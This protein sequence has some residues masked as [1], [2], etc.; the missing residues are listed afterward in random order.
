M[1]KWIRWNQF[2]NHFRSTLPREEV[3]EIA[4]RNF[5]LGTIEFYLTLQA[6]IKMEFIDE[7]YFAYCESHDLKR[8]INF[9]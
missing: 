5:R 2:C 7:P 6:Q 9:Y 4:Q 8:K 3:Q 1:I